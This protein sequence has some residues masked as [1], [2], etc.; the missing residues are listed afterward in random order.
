MEILRFSL[1]WVSSSLY[2]LRRKENSEFLKGGIT[3]NGKSYYIGEVSM[4]NTPHDLMGIEEVEVFGKKALK[5]YGLLGTNYTQAF[6]WFVDENPEDSIIQIDGK[7][8]LKLI[9]TM[10]IR[11]KLFQLW[12]QFPKQK[13]IC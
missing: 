11:K 7:T 3:L 2:Y 13:Y 6:Y 9:W 1:H 10:M 4:E 12:A 8:H 5:I